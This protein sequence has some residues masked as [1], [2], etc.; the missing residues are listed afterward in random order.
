MNLEEIKRIANART[1]DKWFA[2]DWWLPVEISVSKEDAEFIA[3]AAN[4]WDKLMAVVEAAQE[5]LDGM[6]NF[7]APKLHAALKEL[8]DI[9]EE[10]MEELA[11][12]EEWGD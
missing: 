8:E 10:V 11:K 2:A 12:N 9:H 6:G 5:V 1:K 3:M 4:N 7:F